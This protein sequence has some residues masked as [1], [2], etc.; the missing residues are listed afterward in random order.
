MSWAARYYG[1]FKHSMKVDLNMDTRFK[2]GDFV[3]KSDGDYVFAGYVVGII[4][5]IG[6]EIRYAVENADGIV[7]IFSDR[8]IYKSTPYDGFEHVSEQ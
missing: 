3:R 4:A 1:A 6:G 5:K 2:Y 7:H 8:T